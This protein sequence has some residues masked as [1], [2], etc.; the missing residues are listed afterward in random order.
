M[1]MY[2]RAFRSSLLAQFES[3]PGGR[4]KK[5]GDNK[6]KDL[7]VELFE[8]H[9]APTRKAAVRRAPLQ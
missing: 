9:L 4:P 7:V 2:V 6:T 1:N 8:K 5:A 3:M